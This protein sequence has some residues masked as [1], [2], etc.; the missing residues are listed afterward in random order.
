MVPNLSERVGLEL[1]APVAVPA[2]QCRVVE[3]I[4]GIMVLVGGKDG[5]ISMTEACYLTE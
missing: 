5:W 4:V 3:I 1:G 2:A